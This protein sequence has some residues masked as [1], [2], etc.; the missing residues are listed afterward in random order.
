[1]AARRKVYLDTSIFLEMAAKRSKLA[2][3]IKSLLND[4]DADKARVFTSI[5]TVEEFSVAAYRRGTPG[6]DTYGDINGLARIYSIDKD[7]ALTA[8]KHEARLKD[9]A[10]EGEAKR[11]P[12]KGETEE[13]KLER[14]CENRRRKWDCFHL[15]TAQLLECG[16]MFSTDETLKKRPAQLGLTN[17]KV[18]GPEPKKRRIGGPLTDAAGTIDIE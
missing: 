7:I 10:A 13:Q 11:D 1:M 14:I 16:E 5:L 8:A 3:N 2:K 15:A 18:L 4:L 17:I 6:R 12:K 9:I